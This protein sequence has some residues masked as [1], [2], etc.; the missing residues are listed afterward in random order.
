[1]VCARRRRQRSTVRRLELDAWSMTTISHSL[2][3]EKNCQKKVARDP[4]KWGKRRH[5][6]IIAQQVGEVEV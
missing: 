3:R 5:G 4:G 1:M 2:A 6:H